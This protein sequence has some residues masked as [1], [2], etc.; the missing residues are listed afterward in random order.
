MSEKLVIAFVYNPEKRVIFQ[1]KRG[2]I[3]NK[4]EQSTQGICRI[5]LKTRG[6]A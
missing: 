4:N 2:L 5:S 6:M 1:F 3:F